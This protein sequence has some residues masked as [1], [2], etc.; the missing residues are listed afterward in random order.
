MFT[1]PVFVVSREDLPADRH[2]TV[3]GDIVSDKGDFDFR[4]IIL[5]STDL[6]LRRPERQY[7]QHNTGPGYEQL[8][9]EIFPFINEKVSH[10]ERYIMFVHNAGSLYDEMDFALIDVLG[11]DFRFTRDNTVIYNFV[12]GV[13]QDSTVHGL[14]FSQFV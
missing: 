7:D 4:R 6:Y 10:G 3:V 13:V 12:D 2:I 8:H 11:R 1:V 14:Y 9:D 5:S